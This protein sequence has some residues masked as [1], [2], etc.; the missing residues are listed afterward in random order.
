MK[1]HYYPET[2][3]LYIDLR[4]VPA[5]DT[6]EVARGLNADFDESGDVVGFDIDGAS[7]KLDFGTLEAIALPFVSTPAHIER[8][9]SG[10]K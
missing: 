8:I 9:H 10:P 5:A 2:D 1:L 6:R 3:S 7:K 4:D